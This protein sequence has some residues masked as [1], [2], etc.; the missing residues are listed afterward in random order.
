[1]KRLSIYSLMLLLLSLTACSLTPKELQR[2]EQL[3]ESAPDSSLH[4]L[5]HISHQNYMSSSN[6]ALYGLLLFQALDK[7][8]LTLTPDTLINYSIDYY[9]REGQKSRL[10]AAYLYK[11]RMYKYALRFEEATLC[12]M[13]AVDNADKTKDFALLG[14]I[15]NDL[16]DICFKQQDYIK[17]RTEYKH[18]YE[19]FRKT[20][21]KTH[22]LEGLLDVGRTYFAVH[23]YDSAMLY[24]KRALAQSTDSMSKARCIQ[25]ISQNYFAVK[26]Y[27]STLHYLR[28][29]IDYPY[30]DNNRAIRY[31]VLADAY[32]ELRQLDSARFYASETFKFKPDMNVRF[33]CY[34]I[35]GNISFLRK[36]M[37]EM[38][39][40]MNLYTA[41]SDSIKKVDSQTKVSVLE[42]IH[43][44]SKDIQS[45]KRNSI[46]L[47][48]LFCITF[49]LG[50]V[51]LY[52]LYT[53]H[54]KN[55]QLH[56]DQI[57]QA[58]SVLV[59]KQS[60]LV[61]GV[62]QKIEI[63]KQK[64]A[65]VRKKA[66][67]SER[68]ALA[69]EIYQSK[70]HLNDWAEFTR[71][72]NYTFNNI[73]SILESTCPDIKQTEIIWCCLHLLDVPQAERMIVLNVSTNSLYKLK[74]R[75][76]LKLQLN[77]AKMLDEYLKQFNEKLI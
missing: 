36:E 18:K 16:G 2:A 52:Y 41:C 26:Q 46:V 47:A 72:M 59:K 63:A 43:Q 17:A 25:E 77:G 11:G 28:P 71:L 64:Q 31:C 49:L 4:I 33:S 7:N 42:K 73:V 54:K 51:V 50:F 14:R 9:E 10:A 12:L 19:Y 39:H 75:L 55:N 67:Q 35:L 44:D 66:T 27:D 29:I 21:L 69:I 38:A 3:M 6:K 74:Q 13:R 57:Q 65:A 1:M 20:N 30:V 45:G 34:R 60:S 22:A 24:Y 15:Y 48:V 53:Q 5:Q 68:D 32:F 37:K 40:Y 23:K 62:Q 58:H 61:K 56:E 70:L 8:Y 76:A